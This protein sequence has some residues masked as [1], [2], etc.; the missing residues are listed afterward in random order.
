ME[1]RRASAPPQGFASAN[2]KRSLFAFSRILW[3]ENSKGARRGFLGRMVFGFVRVR[4]G[5]VDG[6]FTTW[7]KGTESWEGG[8]L[9]WVG[10]VARGGLQWQADAW[11][12]PRW[13]LVSGSAP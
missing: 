13:R 5:G 12:G 4:L 7:V 8:C 11:S 3:T 6:Y 2:K 9:A 1:R 10:W